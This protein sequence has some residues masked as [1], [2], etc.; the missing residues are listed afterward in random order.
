V[1]NT[2]RITNHR[3]GGSRKVCVKVSS[4]QPDVVGG[5]EDPYEMFMKRRVTATAITQDL[6]SSL[7]DL[8]TRAFGATQVSIEGLVVLRSSSSGKVNDE[9]MRI[10]Q[11]IRIGNDRWQT[12]PHVQLAASAFLGR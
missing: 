3:A 9:A 8:Y 6:A 10:V 5:S 11:P 1:A 4:D 2:A 12:C 7:L